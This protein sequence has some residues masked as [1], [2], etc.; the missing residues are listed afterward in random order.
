MA[1]L[2]VTG[3]TVRV[4]LSVYDRLMA[5]DFR[6]A[7][8]VPLAS[9]TG[10]EVVARPSTSVVDG[11]VAFGWPH[12][13]GTRAVTKFVRIR[14]RDRPGF[15]CVM[16]W[17]GVPAVRVDVEPSGPRQWGMFLVSDRRAAE[18]LDFLASL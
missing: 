3:T 4:R 1:R 15:A 6:A 5:F 16:A 2:E 7:P 10:A 14:L 17:S 13:A 11:M 12:L 18:L 9:V 8:E